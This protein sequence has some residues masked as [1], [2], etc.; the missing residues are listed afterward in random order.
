MTNIATTLLDFRPT[1]SLT[2][3]N[4][5]LVSSLLDM[6]YDPVNVIP[7]AHARTTCVS[8]LRALF[9]LRPGQVTSGVVETPE[10]LNRLVDLL[11]T[12]ERAVDESVRNEALLLLTD[13]AE[14]SEV[15]ATRA[16]GVLGTVC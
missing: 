1:E 16:S 5:S 3:P 13:M 15:R 4:V 9:K 6:L 7:D 12:D 14:A 10:G 11:T 2:D 8:L